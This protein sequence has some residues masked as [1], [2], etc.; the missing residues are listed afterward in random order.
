MASWAL[1]MICSATPAR[2]PYLSSLI[3]FFRRLNSALISLGPLWASWA[4]WVES[5]TV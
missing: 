1:G 4:V 2:L 3:T 5:D